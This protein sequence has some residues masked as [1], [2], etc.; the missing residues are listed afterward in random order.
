VS[1]GR[2]TA[3]VEGAVSDTLRGVAHA[4]HEDD[5]LVGLELGEQEGAGLSIELEPHPPALRAYEIVDADVFRM[6]R[7]DG[8]PEGLAF[9]RLDRADFAATSGT[10][11]LTYVSEE[12]VGGTFTFR[13]EGTL[14]NGGR[15]AASVE[16]TGK[17]NA[18]PGP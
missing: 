3:Y 4:R 7:R 17:V 11:E 16:V 13:M 14:A 9:L 6:D 5:A 10:M 12:Q 15:D 18:P 1:E 8:P 2:F